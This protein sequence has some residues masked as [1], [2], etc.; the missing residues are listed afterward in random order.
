[1]SRPG[2]PPFPKLRTSRRWPASTALKRPPLVGTVF[3][4]AT[5]GVTCAPRN[6]RWMTANGSCQD[7]V[8]ID[9]SILYGGLETPT[10][11][12]R[13]GRAITQIAPPAHQRMAVAKS[14]AERRPIV[15][16][17]ITRTCNLKC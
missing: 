9:I 4:Q 6:V 2:D 1:M 14:A 12:P 17:N 11:P 16:W 8:M 7:H 5:A 10:P 3:V 15:V 13:Y